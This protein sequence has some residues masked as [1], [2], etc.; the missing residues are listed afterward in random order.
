[1][2]YSTLFSLDPETA[3]TDQA[4]TEQYT[5]DTVKEARLWQ[6]F[7]ADAYGYQIRPADPNLPG[8]QIVTNRH[9]ERVGATSMH[10]EDDEEFPEDYSIKIWVTQGY[11]MVHID[12]DADDGSGLTIWEM[13]D[14]D[15][16]EAL[17]DIAQIVA[18][19]D[20]WSEPHFEGGKHAVTP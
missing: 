17:N 12:D 6:R 20:D 14:I 4:Q 7:R 2:K 1:V 13:T 5:C 8:L 11:A 19:H 9:G 16:A 3:G 18:E 10:I 15:I